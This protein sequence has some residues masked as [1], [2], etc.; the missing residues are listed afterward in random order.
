MGDE[1]HDQ[2]LK[3]GHQTRPSDLDAIA[4]L[5]IKTVRYP[6]VWE[7]IAPEHPDQLDWTWTDERLGLLREKGI[8]PVAGLLHH[9][10]GPRYCTFDQD[11]FP[12]TF[13]RFARQVAERYPWLN[14][15]NP[16]NEPLTTARFAGLY[17]IWYPHATDDRTFF[18]ILFNQCKGIVL[19]M[20]EIRQVNPAAQLIQTEDL[21]LT[22]S[23]ERLRYQAKLENHRRWLGFDLL[24]GKVDD[25][26]P[27]WK[28][29]LKSGVTPTELE[30]FVMNP[31]P[32]D[33][34]GM[35]YYL[36][37]ER[38]IGSRD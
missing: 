16:V 5:G 15:Y 17:G 6:V 36:T 34:L 22:Q 4:R 31:C 37:S 10:S 29:L 26:H 7:R 12:E 2:L 20:R 14:L 3:N 28:F 1:Y 30:F 27:L 19:A 25:K 18:R 24:C 21:G 33:I 9:G 38:Y 11:H 13:A 8:N 32:P 23:T 35:D